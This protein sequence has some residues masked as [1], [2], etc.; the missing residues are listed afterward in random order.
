MHAA[1]LLALTAA[2]ADSR[3]LGSTC[4]P[5][6][7]WFSSVVVVG[8]ALVDIATAP[9]SAQRYNRRRV[10]F[11]PL[12]HG[13][14]GRYGVAVSWSYRKA[15]IP[16][17]SSR[18]LPASSFQA[19]PATKSPGT[20]FALSLLS[21]GGPMLVGVAF[22]G[23]A[24]FF[25]VFMSGLVFGPSIGHLYAAQV[26]RGLGTVALRGLGSAA[27]IASIVGCFD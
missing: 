4:T 11:A 21:T 12:V 22:E 18:G 5:G 19:P 6:V 3:A 26:G 16:L 17:P 23:D 9:A 8:S 20:A 14:H 10:A 25:L 7:F 15:P 13:R 27:G 24:P 1:L 2:S